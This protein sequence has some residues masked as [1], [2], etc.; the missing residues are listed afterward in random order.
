MHVARPCS[1]QRVSPPQPHLRRLIC[2][3][4][5]KSPKA[6]AQRPSTKLKDCSSAMPP[7]TGHSSHEA[8][9]MSK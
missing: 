7:V 3:S 5:Y 4:P 1:A 9:R 8:R 2:C 6:I